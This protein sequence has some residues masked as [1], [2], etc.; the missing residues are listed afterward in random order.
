MSCGI[1]RQPQAIFYELVDIIH[2]VLFTLA[3]DI[4]S[5]Q[6]IEL[7][8]KSYCPYSKCKVSCIVKDK[9]GAIYSGVNMENSSFGLTICAER[10]AICEMIKSGSRSI[11]K[12]LITSNQIDNLTPCGAC[13]QTI[14]EV[15]FG[16]FTDISSPRQTQRF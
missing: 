7:L 1:Q 8:D 9:S 16:D 12:I 5:R 11:S 4:Y 14:S 3:M 13:L 6:L 15:F 2:D 10:A